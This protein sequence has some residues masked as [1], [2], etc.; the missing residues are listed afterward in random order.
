MSEWHR[1]APDPPKM[2]A[3]GVPVLVM[4]EGRIEIGTWEDGRWSIRRLGR[5]GPVEWW[6]PMPEG[7]EEER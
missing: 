5:M 1:V 6:R 3:E 2:P 4:F 7:P